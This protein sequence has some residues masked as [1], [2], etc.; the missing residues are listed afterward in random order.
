MADDMQDAAAAQWKYLQADQAQNIAVGPLP[1]HLEAY[2]RNQLD[3]A[4]NMWAPD[5]R[6]SAAIQDQ[7]ARALKLTDEL[8]QDTKKE[9][10]AQKR[11]RKLARASLVLNFLLAAAVAGLLWGMR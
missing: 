3:G 4:R 11:L 1:E 7:F 9:A 6:G 8:I 10:E 5:E 2:R